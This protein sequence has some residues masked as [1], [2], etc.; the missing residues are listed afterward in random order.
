VPSHHDTEAILIYDFIKEKKELL[1]RTQSLQL[2]ARL[3]DS[4][5]LA[6]EFN[7]EIELQSEEER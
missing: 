1:D 3:L 5:R 7:I 6:L 4:A 2:R